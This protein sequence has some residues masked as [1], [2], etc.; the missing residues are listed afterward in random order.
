M[1]TSPPLRA[2]RITRYPGG[3]RPQ[4]ATGDTPTSSFPSRTWEHLLPLA[5]FHFALIFFALL[6]LPLHAQIT[7]TVTLTGK[8]ASQDSTFV[9][10][11]S[12]CGDSPVRHTENWKVGPKGELADV[13]VWIVDPK[14]QAI[15]VPP[16][17]QPEVEVKQ[18][19][20]S[21]VPHVIAV[22]V[23][24]PFKIING[25][26]TLHNIRAK[27]SDGPGKPPGADVFNFGEGRQGQVEER[28][29]DSPG[30]YTLQCDVHPWMQCWVMVLKWGCF[31]VTGTDGTYKLRG[32]DQLADGDYK[33]DAWHPR[34]AQ[35]LEQT[36]HIKNGSAIVN[37]QFDGAKS[38]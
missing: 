14:P 38:F 6:L 5:K 25:D 1:S 13:V 21:Y 30:I 22:Q 28:Q 26:P 15:T 24:T 12:G 3:R 31:G 20:C 23:S 2:V 16:P 9:A 33:I 37:F 8:P 32:G 11:V 36:V 35:M 27:T 7:G 18:L 34:F 10:P 17:A 19:G 29:F 4:E